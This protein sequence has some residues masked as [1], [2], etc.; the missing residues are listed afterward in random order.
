MIRTPSLLLVAALAAGCARTGTGAGVRA[1]IT[2][3]M[4][5]IQAPI[6]QC[7]ATTLQSNRRVRGM[8]V[9]NFRAAAGTGQFDQVSIGRDEPADDGL[10]RCVIDQ[11]SQLKLQT[12][13]RTSVSI[14]YPIRF[15]PND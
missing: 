12:P 2:A 8:M 4:Q 9:V 15:A 11:V 14:A 1:D 3:R 6:Q 13:Q 7:Y 5:S 10:R